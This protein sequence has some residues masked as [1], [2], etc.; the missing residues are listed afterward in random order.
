MLCNNLKWE[1]ASASSQ[2]RRSMEFIRIEDIIPLIGIPEPPYGKRVYNIPCPC[3]DEDPKKRHLNINLN[4]DVFRCPRCGFYG[5]VFDLYAHYAGVDRKGVREVLLARLNMLNVSAR[6]T[7]RSNQQI[8]DECPLIDID[9]RD[10]T[11]SAFLSKLSL[12]GD[13]RDNLKARGLREAEIIRLGYKTSPVVG[14]A[15]IAKQLMAEGHYL[16]GVPGFYRLEDDTWMFSSE[17]RGIL[18]PVRDWKGRIQGLQIRLDDA[19]R[20]KY[21]WISSIG[22]KDGCKAETWS[23]LAGTISETVILTE[24]PMKADIIHSISGKTVVAVPGVNALSHLE[25][26]L[27]ELQSMGV[28]RLMTAFDMDFLVNPHVQNGYR[29]LTEMLRKMGFYYGTY[30]WNPQYKGLDDYIWH[31]AQQ[32]KNNI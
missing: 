4:K 3:C 2:E 1:D 23:H 31:C 24:G 16:S 28:Q 11:Y 5:G 21:R 15:S 29:A 8:P 22:K 10:E 7:S 25:I 26:M 9:A 6:D 27:Q 20:R 30:T 18:I 12:A 17:N 13:H 19:S 32:Q 14:M